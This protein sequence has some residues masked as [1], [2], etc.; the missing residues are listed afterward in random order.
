MSRLTSAL[1]VVA[2]GAGCTTSHGAR[3]GTLTGLGFIS[4]GLIL[5]A[6]TFADSGGESYAPIAP[7]PLAIGAIILGV[8]LYVLFTAKDED[9]AEAPKPPG[10]DPQIAART[11]ARETAWA[12][13]KQAMEAA[14]ANDCT[15]VVKL[16][17]EVRALDAEFYA[18]VFVGD[19]G[20]AR[21]LPQR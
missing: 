19:R 20:I 3:L 18:D 12:L 10:P 13:T 17:A 6:D 7:L 11:K 15:T 9:E 5:R 2:L 21:C 1:L 14:R 8:S 16:D 4:V